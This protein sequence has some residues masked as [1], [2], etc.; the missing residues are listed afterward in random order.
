LSFR[1]TSS[2]FQS[3]FRSAGFLSARHASLEG[4]Y[5]LLDQI[6]ALRWVKRNIHAFGGDPNRVT[7]FGN[8]AGGSS[9][10]LLLASPM[11]V[12]KLAKG[13]S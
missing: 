12:G 13:N 1:A 8:S 2:L 5:G 11:T 9:V 10:G 4:N 7:I 6:E 3:V